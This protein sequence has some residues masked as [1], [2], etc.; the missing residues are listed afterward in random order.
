[1]SEP[2]GIQITCPNCGNVYHAPVR[3][4][5]D[6][7]VEP[8]LRDAFLSGV[9][10]AVACPKC[11]TAIMVE[12]PLVYH[13]P[14]AEFLAVYF[15]PQLNIPEMQKQKM[16]GELTK[17]LMRSLPPDQRK[18]YF[19]SPRQYSTLQN[20]TDAVLGTMGISQ[21]MIDRQR[22]KVK[23]IEQFSVMADDPKGLQMLLKGN[24]S[25]IDVE[26]YTILTN[27]REQAAVTGDQKKAERLRLLEQNLMPLTPFGRRLAKQREAVASLE[28]LDSPEAFFERVV[29]ADLDEAEA[30]ATVARPLMDY[31]FFEQLTGRID[32]VQGPERDRLLALREKL[33]EVTD[34][35]DQAAHAVIRE[36]VELLGDL[37][38]DLSPRSAL[39]A[40]AEEVDELFMAILRTSIQQAKDRGDQDLMSVLEMIQDEAV[41]IIQESYPPEVQFI[42]ELLLQPYPEGT[43]Q[44]LREYRD[45]V[46]PEL[47]DLMA[48]MVEDLGQTDNPN[49]AELA[50]R[51]RDIRAQAMLLV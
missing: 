43:R 24:E 36:K 42:N 33:L 22:K 46:T 1:M 30:I 28:K 8:R 25:Q 31:T 26:F 4:I 47:L 5:I 13:D 11:Q 2:Q 3:S 37:I 9:L 18:G 10:N 44:M 27:M 48:R 15:P 19:L 49:S 17:S 34:R 14:D 32:A 23:L 20:L 6:V 35:L 51:L 50:K 21:E 39:R 7:G 29:K 38:S 40:H 41:Q 16:I 45:E 12:V